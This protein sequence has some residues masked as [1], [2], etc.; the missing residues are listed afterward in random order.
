MTTISVRT[1]DFKQSPVTMIVVDGL[2][3]WLS[4][5]VGR[6]L[7]YAR[8]GEKLSRNIQRRWT[9]IERGPDYILLT[10]EELEAV[11]GMV[12][13]LARTRRVLMLSRSGLDKVLGRTKLDIAQP[14]V[15]WLTERGMLIGD[16][17]PVDFGTFHAART[18]S[19]RGAQPRDGYVGTD[20]DLDNLFM[21]HPPHT[22]QPERYG[23][24]RAAAKVFAEEV[25]A[26]CPPG[27][28]RTAAIRKIREAVMTANAAI[29]CGEP[30]ETDSPPPIVGKSVDVMHATSASNGAPQ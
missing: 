20:I 1:D 27:A 7:G 18:L 16:A 11:R 4:R 30:Q 8:G 9:E 19:A 21:Y 17:S 3:R 13:R 22:D 5:D 28:D 2:P 29:A 14:F 25:V 10:G 24:L 6:A 26:C 23:R 12:P 15:A